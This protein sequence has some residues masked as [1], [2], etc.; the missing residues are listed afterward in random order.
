MKKIKEVRRL[1]GVKSFKGERGNFIVDALFNRK[2]VKS[3]ESWCYVIT[4]FKSGQNS[5]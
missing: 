3:N 4:I 5:P 2:P 1:F